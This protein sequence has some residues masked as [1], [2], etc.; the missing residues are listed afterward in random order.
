MPPSEMADS[1][2]SRWNLRGSCL[3]T[4]TAPLRLSALVNLQIQPI[5]GIFLPCHRTFLVQF[6]FS[7]T[8]HPL[9]L[10]LQ[11]NYPMW[12]PL[13]RFFIPRQP[14]PLPSSSPSSLSFPELLARSARTPPDLAL[15]GDAPSSGRTASSLRHRTTSS[16]HQC[17]FSSLPVVQIRRRWLELDHDPWRSRWGSSP[18]RRRGSD[19]PAATG[20]R[21]RALRSVA[22]DV[23][24]GRASPSL[25]SSPTSVDSWILAVDTEYKTLEKVVPFSSETMTFDYRGYLQCAFSKYLKRR[26]KSKL[27]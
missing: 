6:K 21:A 25:L 11:T 9:Y 20:R 8:R 26:K 23:E 12:G 13:I 1:G 18:A 4:V 17:A 10:K 15:Q 27:N 2:S 22:G 3:M 5:K 7:R 14:H 19:P 16:L 24:Q